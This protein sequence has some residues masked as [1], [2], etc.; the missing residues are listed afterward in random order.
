MAAVVTEGAGASAQDRNV[1]L[2]TL[3]QCFKATNF[4]TGAVEVFVIL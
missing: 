3:E 4:T 2:K 1:A